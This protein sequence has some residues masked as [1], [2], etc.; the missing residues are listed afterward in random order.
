MVLRNF[1]SKMK[2]IFFEA[3]QRTGRKAI[4]GK[5]DKQDKR[6]RVLS[7]IEQDILQSKSFDYKASDKV[8]EE[9]FKELKMDPKKLPTVK[10]QLRKLIFYQYSEKYKTHYMIRNQKILNELTEYLGEETAMNFFNNYEYL[11]EAAENQ[12]I[13]LSNK[14]D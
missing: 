12:H 4:K 10:K 2:N 7:S 5:I 13:R 9:I 1:K 8:T 14:F 6:K 11:M 3:R